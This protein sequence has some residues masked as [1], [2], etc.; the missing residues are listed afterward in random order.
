MHNICIDEKE[1]SHIDQ[2]KI[3]QF[4]SSVNGSYEVETT[5]D[6]NLLPSDMLHRGEYSGHFDRR[7]V[8]L[9]NISRKEILCVV[10][11]NDLRQPKPLKRT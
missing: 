11:E 3:D 8:S 5:K 10:C 2:I 9:C 1:L 6:S 7:R 4:Y